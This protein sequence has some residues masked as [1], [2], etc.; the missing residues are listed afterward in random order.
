MTFAGSN[1]G[2]MEWG[3]LASALCIVASLIGV[4]TLRSLK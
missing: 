1:A 2:L 4:A 3:G